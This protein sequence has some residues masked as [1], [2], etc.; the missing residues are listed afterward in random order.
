MT[1]W[2]R[3]QKSEEAG[4]RM[5]DRRAR[6]KE[7]LQR[8]AAEAEREMEEVRPLRRSAEAPV[9]TAAGWG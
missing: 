3:Q 7:Q 8:E 6:L 2:Q 5:A 4:S 1:A 9:L